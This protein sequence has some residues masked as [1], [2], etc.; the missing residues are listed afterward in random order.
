MDS[1]RLEETV[2]QDTVGIINYIIAQR[3]VQ[4]AF[5]ADAN[6]AREGGN[7]F[8]FAG[9]LIPIFPGCLL[10]LL[11]LGIVISAAVETLASHVGR[12]RETSNSS[13]MRVS[14]RRYGGRVGVHSWGSRSVGSQ[15]QNDYPV[16][17][18]SLEL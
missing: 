4:L 8:S 14:I 12:R 2:P 10:L 5:I 11:P 13:N 1:I 17:L 18:T 15:Y 3:S 9:W 16:S 6:K 7:G